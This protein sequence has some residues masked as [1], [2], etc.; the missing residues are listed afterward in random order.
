MSEKEPYRPN[1]W[2]DRPVEEVIDTYAHWAG[3]YDKDITERGYHTPVR[4]ADALGRFKSEFDGPILDFGCGT[5]IS[6]LALKQK[7][8]GPIHGTD[9]TAEMLSIAEEKRIYERLW[10][11]KPGEV[12]NTYSVIVAAGVIS[13]GAAPPETLTNCVDAIAPTGL[14][15]FSYNDK[16]LENA[17]YMAVLEAELS[18]NRA[19]VIFREHGPHL[20]D[21]RMGSDIIILRRK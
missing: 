6:G 3:S 14:L 15:A 12:P 13:V 16:T 9:I 8:L 18:Q 5:G 4:I 1:L 10:L 20:D 7:G 2:I 21:M 17:D 11:S 19:N